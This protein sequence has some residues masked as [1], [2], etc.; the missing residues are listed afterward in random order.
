[1][2]SP[3]RNSDI[4]EILLWLLRQRKRFRVV[5]FSM[6]PWLQP[7]DEVLVDPNAYGRSHPSIHDVVIVRHPKKANFLLIKR[8]ISVGENGDCFIQ[9]DNIAQSTDSRSFGWIDSQL[10]FGRVTSRFFGTDP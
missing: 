9:G 5:D 4:V 7:G 8:V 3:I 1:M 2:I 10:I 6:I